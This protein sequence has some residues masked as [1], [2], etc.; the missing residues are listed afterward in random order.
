[1]RVLF[2]ED[3]RDF[4]AEVVA[5]LEAIGV[6]VDWVETA[7]DALGCLNSPDYDLAVCDLRIPAS[8]AT[9]EVHKEHGIRVIDHIRANLPA[10]P[11]IV[12]SAI[13]NNMEDLGD[14]LSDTPAQD[15]FGSGPE[16]MLLTRS[17]DDITV[18]VEI[19]SYHQEAIAALLQA[20]EVSGAEARAVM[21]ELDLR[22]VSNFT[23]RHGGNAVRLS[24][25][26]GGMSGAL[27]LRAE[28]D[29]PD[30]TPAGRLFAKLG[31]ISEVDDEEARYREFA[32]MLN[33]SV[34]ANLLE[35]IYCGAQQRGGLFYS[36]ADQYDRSLFS[37]LRNSQGEAL[38]AV[39]RL[40]QN[41][42][43]WHDNWTLESASVRSVREGFVTDARLAESRVDPD[44][45][46]DRIEDRV[47][48][49]RRAPSHR[50]LHGE[51]ALVS[52]DSQPILIDFGK[53]GRA[54]ASSDPVFLELSAVLH[55]KADLDLGEW[56][57]VEQAFHWH[58]RGRYL[59]GCPI[60]DFVGACR[61]WTDHV[62]AGDLERDA[63]V[64]AT[65]LRQLRFPDVP[66]DLPA[67]F[68]RGAAE[69]LSPTW[70]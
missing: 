7:A 62:A 46:T 22:L 4:G 50:D 48:R 58:D 63:V 2:V 13:W 14:R 41:L 25:I 27:A 42:A 45:V 10:L 68:S 38:V 36:L 47:I 6:V 35:S 59:E 32:L 8:G 65:A 61:D 33:A 23:R 37:V 54:P 12:F 40:R 18:L 44:W 69:R 20:V 11:V 39:S 31:T 30:G 1:M 5:E 52:T 3:D 15:L 43:P 60:A 57:S 34:Y 16:R 55:P 9:T 24:L 67:A 29:R 49:V 64:Y 26:A 28:I 66:V 19:V 21:S 56:P 51:N 53:V 70:P 17:K